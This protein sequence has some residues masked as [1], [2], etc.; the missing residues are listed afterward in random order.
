[1]SCEV[2]ASEQCLLRANSATS[3]HANSLKTT[4]A[5]CWLILQMLHA[6]FAMMNE[7]TECAG[8]TSAEQQTE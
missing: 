7:Y 6:C 2:N 3:L 5:P 8:L 4:V 1:M